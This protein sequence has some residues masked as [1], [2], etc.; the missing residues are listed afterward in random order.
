M[1]FTHPEL[2]DRAYGSHGKMMSALRKKRKREARKERKRLE[3]EW[4]KAT[5]GHRIVSGGA[6]GLGKKR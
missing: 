6:P 5:G 2:P 3:R 1:G 4:V